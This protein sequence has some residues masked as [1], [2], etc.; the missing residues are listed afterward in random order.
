M[1]LLNW[2]VFV[3]NHWSRRNGESCG[4]G[5]SRRDKINININIKM[6]QRGCVLGVYEY[7]CYLKRCLLIIGMQA[8]VRKKVIEC[9]YAMWH[10]LQRRESVCVEWCCYY[11]RGKGCHL[12]S[13]AKAD[14]VDRPV[15]WRR[16]SIYWRLFQWIF[17]R[18]R[19]C[20]R[21]RKGFF[22]WQWF[23]KRAPQLR[24]LQ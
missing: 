14:L 19:L 22:R 2:L 24:I 23:Y 7:M 16:L 8:N 3:P 5:D 6:K 18:V 11:L 21:I 1:S 4:L 12:I 15:W 13:M 10:S 20:R 17:G 9:R